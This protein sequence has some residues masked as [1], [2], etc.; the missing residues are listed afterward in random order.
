MAA[1]KGH[2]KAGGRA[3]GSKNKKTLLLETFAQTI[4]EGGMERFRSELNK[5]SGKDYVNAYLSL[6]R[7]C[8]PTLHKTEQNITHNVTKEF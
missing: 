1:K 7:Y 4:V 6:M 2:K 8:A 5:L 3:P